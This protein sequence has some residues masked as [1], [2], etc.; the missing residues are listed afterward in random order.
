M[1]YRPQLPPRLRSFKCRQVYHVY[2]RGSQRQKV[3]DSRA[4][5][6]LYLDRLD[7]L[8][9]RYKVRIHAFC[10]M[11]NHV[12][13]MFEP[14]RRGG[15]SRLMQHLQSQHARHMNALRRT[16][17]HLW[18]HHFHAKHVENSAQY[19]AT[20]LYIEQNPVAA[21]MCERAH[22]YPFSSAVAH[23][24]NLPIYTIERHERQAQVKLYLD[25]WR[26]E[27]DI[28]AAGPATG[29]TDW[30]TWLRSPRQAAYNQDLIKEVKSIE[31]IPLHPPYRP[32][33][34][35][36]ATALAVSPK[37]AQKLRYAYVAGGSARGT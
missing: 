36:P 2:Q 32:T 11:S 8:A 20:L 13:F 25:R 4:Q 14:L 18:R 6:V 3:F 5:I 30:P 35:P 1:A 24:L 29:P 7:T 28:P 16:D 15:I 33:P 37:D 22:L 9:R 26:K 31:G 10:I 12:H 19:T 23:T 27:F 21:G 34:L 17:G